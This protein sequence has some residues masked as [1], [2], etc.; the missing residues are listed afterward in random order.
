[1][2]IAYFHVTVKRVPLLI[3]DDATCVKEKKTIVLLNWSSQRNYNN[4]AYSV[5]IKNSRYL[6]QKESTQKPVY[7]VLDS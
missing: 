6:Y 1:M 7:C 4:S 5:L 2:Y 3:F